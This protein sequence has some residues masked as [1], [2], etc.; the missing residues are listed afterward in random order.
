MTYSDRVTFIE[1]STNNNM[2]N[3]HESKIQDEKMWKSLR[4]HI[5]SQRETNKQGTYICNVL[6]ALIIT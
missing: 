4:S 1:E 3:R 5:L 6:I 2:A